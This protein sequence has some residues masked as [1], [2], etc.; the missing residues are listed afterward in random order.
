MPEASMSDAKAH[1]SFESLLARAACLLSRWPFRGSRS[2]TSP[3][4]HLH[5][6]LPPSLPTRLPPYVTASSSK[7]IRAR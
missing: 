2:V 6:I 7:S 1:Q 3:C 5:H 4:L